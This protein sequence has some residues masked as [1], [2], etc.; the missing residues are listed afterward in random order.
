MAKDMTELQRLE[1][2]AFILKRPD[3]VWPRQ[4]LEENTP[5]AYD[6]WKQHR[7]VCERI[8]AGNQLIELPQGKAWFDYMGLPTNALARKHCKKWRVTN[9][10]DLLDTYSE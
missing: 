7:R 8:A 10:D 4:V 2:E 1:V 5:R 6:I 9:I 3:A